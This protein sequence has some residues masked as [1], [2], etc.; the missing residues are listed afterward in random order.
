MAPDLGARV[1]VWPHPG[2][3]V[4][5]LP[6]PIDRPLPPDGKE[7]SWS[8]WLYER[9]RQGDVLLTSPSPPSPATP[10]E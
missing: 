8:A 4:S 10:T 6:P 1:H 7:C 9:F 2:R 5:E 3:Q